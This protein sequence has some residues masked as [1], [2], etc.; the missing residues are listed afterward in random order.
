[1]KLIHR[2]LSLFLIVTFLT[3]CSI[4]VFSPLAVGQKAQAQV[5]L[6]ET[7]TPTPT[8]T[9]TATLYVPPLDATATPTPF[10]PLPPTPV[11]L[12]TSTPTITPTPMPTATPMPIVVDRSGDQM[13]QPPNQMTVLLL[14]SDKRPWGTGFRTDTIILATLNMD[15]GTI[16]L[17]SFPRDL[18]VD[19]PNWGTDRINTAWGHGGFKSLRATFEQN[20]GVRPDHYVL[21]NFSAFKQFVDTLGGLEVQVKQPLND[22]RAGRWVTI[23]KGRQYMDADTVLW[24]VRSRKT[25]SD[26]YRN[27]R[28]QEVLRA[29]FEKLLTTNSL[30]RIP[31]F[32]DFYKDNVSTDLTWDDISPWLPLATRLTDPDQLT[33]YYVGPD[34]AYDWVTYEGAMVLIPRLPLIKKTLRQALNVP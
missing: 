19:I 24:Y 21:I 28:Q 12:P 32:Y 2:T 29:V 10:Q 14:G 5:E 22:Y 6:V 34:A 16:N 23:K 25:T 31:E 4:P 27:R 18:Y 17:M 13:G 3:G 1:M 33:S 9:A 20:F 15:L 26:F 7:S 11:Y 8:L 30:L